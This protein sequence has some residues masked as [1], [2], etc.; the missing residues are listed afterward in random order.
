[1]EGHDAIVDRFIG[2]GV[3]EGFTVS[4]QSVFGFDDDDALPG[5]RETDGAIGTSGAT[6]DDANVAGDD[7]GGGVGGCINFGRGGGC[8]GWESGG[9]KEEEE[10]EERG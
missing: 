7:V 6:A 10:V 8:E 1:M 3:G 4:A 5:I 2:A 9:E